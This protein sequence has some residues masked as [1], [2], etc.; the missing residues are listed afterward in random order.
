MK[1]LTFSVTNY[2]SITK[3][4]KI[5]LEAF[6][7]LV[8]KNNEGKS[9]LL[10]ALNI[11][12]EILLDHARKGNIEMKRRYSRNMI[13]EWERD[14]PIQL[15]N[16]KRGLESIFKLEF[17]LEGEE[18][19][20]F[21]KNTG[22]RGNEDIP[23]EIKIDKQN[24]IN[25]AVLKKG[26][27]SYN[28]KSSQVANFISTRLNFNYIQA[29]RTDTMAIDFLENV[30]TQQLY[31]LN[32]NDEYVN[33]VNKIN[34]LEDK[35]L[36][37]ISTQLLEPLKLFLPNLSDVKIIKDNDYNY[38]QIRYRGRDI[39][40]IIDD[41]IPTNISYKGDGIKS[42][43]TLAILKDRISFGRASI[44]AIEEP[45]SHL[46]SGAI[47]NLVNVILNI[48]KNNQVIIT[49]HNPLFVQRNNIKSNIIVND[50]KA[51]PAKNIM[52]VRNILGV[53]P[54]DNLRNASHVLVVEGENDKIMLS[55]IL[56]L[57]STKISS[58]ISNNKLVI[59]SLGGASN[60]AHD[61][62]DLKNSMCKFF[63]LMDNDKAGNDA[64]KIAKS[65]SLITEADYKL[66]ICNGSP[67]SEIE[68]CIK[69]E[70]YEEVLLREFNINLDCKEFRNNKK[71]S[72]KIK[73]V[74]LSKGG[75]WNDRIES[76][77]KLKVA[78]CVS[79]CNNSEEILIIQKSGFVEGLVEALERMLE[80]Q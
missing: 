9:N 31:M 79:K 59:K 73:D 4:H 37:E 11:A 6:T 15:Q 25:I 75:N 66:T 68:D 71:W 35:I 8:G 77:I 53:L 13:Y 50:G 61:V 67:E 46:H 34:E 7:V 10:T 1:L 54:E 20:E 70:V 47:H 24:K 49:T 38:R 19:T 40:I 41:G 26:T 12:M 14:F 39:K 21:Q 48:S 80:I 33:A 56:S 30:I 2:R 3:A 76:E 22:I 5:N 43:A 16:R 74:R 69:K 64:L 72:D 51:V 28:K 23:I 29:V 57:K 32:D 65:K 55:K 17:K 60:L 27:S 58:A 36:K 44:I 18:L 78:E 52:E 63:I 62:L 42:L 45:E